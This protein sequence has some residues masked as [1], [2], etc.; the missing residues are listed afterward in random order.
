MQQTFSPSYISMKF[1]QNDYL[2]LYMYNYV[3][4]TIC[5][6]HYHCTV[7]HSTFPGGK[8][9]MTICITHIFRAVNSIFTPS[10]NLSFMN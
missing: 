1:Q 9:E 6:E 5:A 10:N 7:G 4:V 2:E 3:V 8:E